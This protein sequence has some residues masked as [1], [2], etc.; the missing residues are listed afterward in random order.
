MTI[1]VSF[2]FEIAVDIT[3]NYFQDSMV[4]KVGDPEHVVSSSAYILFYR[5]RSS[6]ALG[7]PFFEEIAREMENPV[8]SSGSQS[9]SRNR[10][11]SATEAGEGQR[12]EDS[13]RGFSSASHEAGA[14]RQAGNGGRLRGLGTTGETLNDDD[15]TQGQEDDTLPD[16]AQDDP[17]P[18]QSMELDELESGPPALHFQNNWGFQ[19]LGAGAMSS[20]DMDVNDDGHS[21]TSQEGHAY[22]GYSRGNACTPDGDNDS[23]VA[24]QDGD[25]E[26]SWEGIMDEPEKNEEEVAEIRLD[27]K[28]DER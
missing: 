22:G 18:M 8:E 10:S 13:S 5:R 3:A 25:L 12:L 4:S 9:A 15:E 6:T 21:I 19:T 16:Y 17:N 1:T 20:F 2:F 28:E 26:D 23:M 14:A 11:P 24:N 7:G 27:T